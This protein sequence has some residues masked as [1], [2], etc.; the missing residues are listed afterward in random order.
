MEEIDGRMGPVI[1]LPDGRFLAVYPEGR[2]TKEWDDTTIPEYMMG[3]FSP[4][5]LGGWSERQ[6]LFTFPA[7]PGAAGMGITSGGALPRANR[8]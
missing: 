4:D 7:G 8:W 3:R 2:R 1:Q 6:V 5:G